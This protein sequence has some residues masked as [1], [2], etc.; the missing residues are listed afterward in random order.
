MSTTQRKQKMSE[1]KNRVCKIIE[2]EK[3]EIV[4][5]LR[6]LVQIPTVVGSEGEGQKYI[7]ELYAA[8]S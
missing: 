4:Q 7:Q 2:D 3:E 6:T 8:W 1:A 5:T